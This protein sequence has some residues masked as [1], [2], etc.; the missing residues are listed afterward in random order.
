[1]KRVILVLVVLAL[2]ALAVP[3]FAQDNGATV[4]KFGPCKTGVGVKAE[5]CQL[6]V[7]PSGN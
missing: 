7:T 3:T 5:Q 4:T 2:L 6:V 1:M